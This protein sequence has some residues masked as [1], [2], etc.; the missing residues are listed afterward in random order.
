ME[1]PDSL[2][3]IALDL[4][5]TSFSWRESSLLV[6]LNLGLEQFVRFLPEFRWL[7]AEKSLFLPQSFLFAP[8]P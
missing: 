2:P 5:G 4:A 7:S 1:F 6:V 8:V 3:G